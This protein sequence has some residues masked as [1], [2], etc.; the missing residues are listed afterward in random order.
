[1]QEQKSG[2]QINQKSFIQ[3]VLILLALMV[4][5]GILTLV[6]PAGRYQRESLPDGREV[7]LPGTFATVEKHDYPIWRWFT[8]PLEVLVAEGSLTVIV[9]L[10]FL[11]FVGI[12]FAILDKS[13][14][15]QAALAQ[16]VS[17]FG[18]QKYALL[19]AI[20]FFF[21]CLGA[22]FGIFEEVLPLV[23]LMVALAYSLGW[24]ALTGLGMS[25]LATNVGFST[26][27]TNPFTIGVAQKLAGLPLF[28]GAG[29]RLVLFALAYLLLAAFLTR[30]AKR[31]ERNPEASPVFADESAERAHYRN[32]K[33][34]AASIPTGNLQRAGAWL[35]IFLL[36]ILAAL[37]AAPFVPFLTDYALPV[38]GLLFLLAGVG[39]G[40][41]SGA[42]AR[43]V[44]KAVAE[45]ATG[46]APA[47]PLVLMAASVRHIVA[48]GGILDTLLYHAAGIFENASAF[49]ASLLVY[50][51]ALA[52]EFFIGSGSAKAVLLMPILLPL[53]DLVGVS[54]Q[55]AV[56]AYCFGDGFSNLA[57]PTNPVLLIS[58]GL[59]VV[60]YPKWIKWLAG[61]WVWMFALTIG[62]LALAVAIGYGPF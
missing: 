52:V 31:V 33:F 44:F 2:A 8:A 1:M 20:S 57:Y 10:I 15:L 6:V 21:M 41:L 14:I 19:L 47:I 3:S 11:L 39:A 4:A 22:F 48:S 42:G 27:I 50:A 38:V 46:I 45:G 17:R 30:Y 62:F 18:G 61:L 53:A 16:I 32:Y 43:T 28:S 29:P 59:T 25:I 34:D 36:L 56:T 51:I 49:G 54:R 24:D 58:L 37:M 12:A 55:I 40:F 23:P 60:S 13:G 7:I 35:G 9:I 5:S 26:A